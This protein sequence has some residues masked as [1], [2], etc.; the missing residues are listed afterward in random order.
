MSTL[1]DGDVVPCRLTYIRRALASPAELPY[2]QLRMSG[3]GRVADNLRR[4][5]GSLGTADL[6]GATDGD[7]SRSGLR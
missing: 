1:V 5:I 2:D 3:K 4:G 6:G 7:L